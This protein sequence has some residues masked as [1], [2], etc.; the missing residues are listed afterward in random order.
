[1]TAVFSSRFA[2][3]SVQYVAC[4]LNFR[5][6]LRPERFRMREGIGICALPWFALAVDTRRGTNR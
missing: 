1:M 5:P 2:C 6:P 3:C 4:V